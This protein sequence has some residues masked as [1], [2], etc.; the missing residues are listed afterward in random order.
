[1]VLTA[2]HGESLGEH[3]ERTHGI[4][5]YEATL[6]VPLVVYGPRLLRPRLVE[7]RVQHVDLLPT[8]LDAVAVPPPGALPGHSLLP[9]AAGAP[10]RDTPAY[11]EALS[12]QTT[13]GWAPLHGVVRGG[14]KYVD[15]PLPELYDLA[16]DPREESNLAAARP[17]EM[18]RLRA[19][20]AELRAQ[21]RG[22]RSATED[23]ETRER[24]RALGYLSSAAPAEGRA[25]TADD[26]PKRLIELDA[27]IETV[28]ARHRA[29]DVAGARELCEE[30]VRRRPGMPSALLQLGAAPPQ[31]G[32]APGRRLRAR[33]GAGGIA[34]RRGHGRAAGQ[35]PERG[36]AGEGGGAPAGA[37]RAPRGA[38]AGR[39]GGARHRAL[40]AGTPP[41]GRGRRWARPRRLDP[42]NA[43]T[44]RAAGHG[45]PAGRRPR[46]RAKRR[47]RKRCVSMPRWP[48]PTARWAWWPSS[49]AT[50]KRRCGIGRRRSRSILSSTTRCCAWARPWPGAAAATKPAPTWSASSP[51][52]RPPIY[53]QS[54]ASATPWLR[55]QPSAVKQTNA[56]ETRRHRERRNLCASVPLW[57]FRCRC[58]AATAG[59]RR[60]TARSGCAG[61]RRRSSSRRA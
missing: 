19:A 48:S 27:M 4:F 15:L 60:G 23:R 11:F 55:A 10:A 6:R 26:D 28:L 29:G 14:W 61:S 18:D 49:G 2:D 9:A 21:D 17:Q 39:A 53:A 3:G 50:L 51:P 20:L 40:A 38:G 42:S 45:G 32:A 57:L 30:V 22:P 58:L 41:R 16:R 56:T 7:S 34:R 59:R 46:R 25:Y 54:L 52:P 1:M 33:A 5:A 13:R 36:R 31:V 12:G 24:L 35:L 8:I 43:M 47:W 37:V 44:Q